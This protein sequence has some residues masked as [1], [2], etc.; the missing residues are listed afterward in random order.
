MSKCGYIAGTCRPRNKNARGEG[1][2]MERGR[3]VK[4]QESRTRKEKGQ[5]RMSRGGSVNTF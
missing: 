3:G 2:G 1:A 4:V 5:V